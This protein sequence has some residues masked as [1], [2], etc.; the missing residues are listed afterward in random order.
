MTGDG[1]AKQTLEIRVPRSALDSFWAKYRAKVSAVVAVCGI[2]DCDAAAVRLVDAKDATKAKAEFVRIVSASVY[3]VAPPGDDSG[4]VTVAAL[5]ALLA[6]SKEQMGRLAREKSEAGERFRGGALAIRGDCEIDE[7]RPVFGSSFG[8]SAAR[9]TAAEAAA[10]S[11]KSSSVSSSSQRP[12][13]FGSKTARAAAGKKRKPAGA[14]GKGRAAPKP[15]VP[16]KRRVVDSEEDTDEE[17]GDQAGLRALERLEAEEEEEEAEAASGR[18]RAG[19]ASGAGKARAKRGAGRGGGGLFAGEGDEDED[20]G[21][22]VTGGGAGG[23]DAEDAGGASSSSSGKARSAGGHRRRAGMAATADVNTGT[24]DSFRDGSAAGKPRTRRV[25][26]EETFM[27]ERGYMVTKEVVVEVPVEEGDEP[28]QASSSEPK[29]A[30]AKPTK[31]KP[32]KTK[33]QPAGKPKQKS[34]A[35]FF[36]KR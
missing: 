30:K 6:R 21:D 18:P 2:V 11:R 8:A 12:S 32:A 31:A 16:S 10:V 5:D 20:D 33:T 19:R 7:S 36:G 35:S 3:C 15:E 24:F 28:E 25:L 34:L 17:D 9:D 4:R 13:F 22:D 27:D 1:Q 23:E 29:P 14:G 26:K